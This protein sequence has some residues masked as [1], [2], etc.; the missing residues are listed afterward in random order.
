MS[1]NRRLPLK[2]SGSRPGISWGF[3]DQLLSSAAT[4]TMTVVAGRLLGAVGLGVIFV[5]FAAY[6]VAIGVQR[7]LVVEPLIAGLSRTPTA[8]TRES[9]RSALTIVGLG[10]FFA[11]GV[12]VTVGVTMTGELAR[13]LLLFAPWV[14][15]ALLQD[16]LRATLFRDG[17]FRLATALEAL[18]FGTLLCLLPLV[19][20]ADSDWAIVGAWGTGALVAA[21]VGLA[22]VQIRPQ[23]IS[24]AFQ[25]W[26]TSALSLGRWLAGA[27]IVYSACMFGT[28]MFLGLILGPAS[29]GGLRAVLSVMTPLSLIAPAISLPG[30]PAIARASA[31]SG[32]EA[33]RLALRLGLLA[34][35]C[36]AGYVLVVGLAPGLLGLLF[37]TAFNEYADLVWP[38]GLGQIIGVL[39][40]GFVLLLKAEQR[41]RMFFAVRS[42]ASIVSLSLAT[43]LALAFG[44]E[45]AAWGFALA[46]MIAAA[47]TTLVASPRRNTLP[48]FLAKT[49]RPQPGL[50]PRDSRIPIARSPS[51]H[52]SPR[53][54]VASPWPPHTPPGCPRKGQPGLRAQRSG[55][56]LDQHR[57][58]LSPSHSMASGATTPTGLDPY[59][60]RP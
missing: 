28:I 19:L 45:G 38:L 1:P 58:F 39:A 60:H 53:R 5:G 41:G 11:A 18:W 22:F 15:P 3:T 59:G 26:R 7:A 50:D 55:Q 51:R 47:F 44:L 31:A 4:L 25:W 37:G 48:A 36:A 40:I 8:E 21:V 32:A 16:F 27:S 17:R 2:M 49:L 43:L 30:L 57:R 46:S 24:P 10:A 54:S 56:G 6:L 29:L 35:G 13:G 14:I 33:R 23:R 34:S 12:L 42:T 52:G 20:R 9:S